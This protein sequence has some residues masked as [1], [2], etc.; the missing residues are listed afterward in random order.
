MQDEGYS[1]GE[2]TRMVKRRRRL[3]GVTFFAFAVLSVVVAYSLETLYRSLGVIV[4]E[5]PEVADQEG[6]PAKGLAVVLGSTGNLGD[7]QAR[8]G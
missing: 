8:L 3:I 1:V 2:V 6:K 7:G 5:Q 4:I